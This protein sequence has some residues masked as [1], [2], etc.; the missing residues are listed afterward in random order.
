MI[1][2]PSAKINIGLYVTEKREDGYHNLETIFLPIGLKDALEI[3]PSVN[4]A[5]MEVVGLPIHGSLTD[6]LVWKAFTI[7]K[8]KFPERIPDFQIILQKIIPMGA[9]LGGGS[10]D[11]AN[12]LLLLNEYCTLNLS[13]ETLVAI[14]LELGSDCP[15]FIYNVPQLAYGK[16]EILQ[17]IQLPSMHDY[18]LEIFLPKI[19]VSTAAAFQDIKPQQANFNLANIYDLPVTAWQGIIKN[20]FETTVMAKYPSLQQ[21]KDAIMY[22]GAIYTSMTGTGSAIY[23]IVPKGEHLALPTIELTFDRFYMETI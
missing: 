3:I 20:D 9:G 7:M 1:C 10:S 15:F 11:A 18:S 4:D 17:P 13:T 14:A 22:A 8:K 12:L 19:H 5:S 6:N 16:G 21:L 23:A 2:F